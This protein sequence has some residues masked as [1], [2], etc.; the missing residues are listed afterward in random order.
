VRAIIVDPSAPEALR[1]AEVPEPTVAPG[2]VLVDVH[3]VSLNGGDLN[4]T[5]SGRVL[6]GG[7]PRSDATG[8]VGRAASD[9]GGPAPARAW[10]P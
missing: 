3:D 8:V 9:G 2:Q 10:L 5:R 1:P 4:D 6:P 7:V